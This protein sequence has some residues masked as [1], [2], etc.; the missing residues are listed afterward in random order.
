[1]PRELL[2]F[3]CLF[4]SYPYGSLPYPAELRS[5]L[6]LNVQRISKESSTKNYSSGLRASSHILI[7]RK[8][9]KD[10]LSNPFHQTVLSRCHGWRG[11]YTFFDLSILLVLHN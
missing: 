6:T 2:I 5:A 3:L 9:Q 1:M 11:R 7:M 10:L 8:H 4:M